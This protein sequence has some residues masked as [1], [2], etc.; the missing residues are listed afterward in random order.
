MK[1]LILLIGLLAP[2]F[3]SAQNRDAN[4]ILDKVDQ[5]MSANSR[6]MTA[7]MQ[8]NSARATRTMEM[9]TWAVGDKKAFTEYLSPARERG[10]KMLKLENRLWI[11]SP[12]TDRT[13]QISGHMLRQSVMGSDLSYEDMMND[14]P[15]QEQYNAEITGEEI[16][17]GRNCK[18]LTLT[19]KIPDV[20][21]YMQKIWVDEERFVMLKAQQFAK[22]G[23]MLKQMTLSD[24]QK[25][26]GRWFPMRFLY[27]DMLKSGDGTTFSIKTIRF[28]EN[29]PES[30]FN[31]ANLR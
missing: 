3:T 27:K 15:L 1:K 31:K 26:Q 17:D 9:K 18:V 25:V 11:Y 14:K 23:K 6:I 30:V 29:I 8:V 2:V 16:V 10:T 12:S 22:S 4:S 24:V 28:D 21:Y 5:N 13:I 20:N 19:A 7:E